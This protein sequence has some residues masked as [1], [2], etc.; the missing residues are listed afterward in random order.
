M[1]NTVER[2]IDEL[3]EMSHQVSQNEL[4]E[5]AQALTEAKRIF[6]AGAG[7]SGCVARAFSNRLMHLGYL[8][9]FVGE[10][11]T[12]P[13]GEGDVLFIIS[14]SGKTTSLIN[15]AKKVVQCKATI[16]TMTIRTEDLENHPI[17]SMASHIIMLPGSTRLNQ[18]G[19]ESIQPVG[20][21]FEQLC[22]LTCDALIVLL[23]Q[24][25]GL[26]NNDLLKNHAN[27]E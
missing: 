9:Y 4:D 8:V 23:K 16:V 25:K 2:I 3:T 19:M 18:T 5:M 15:M 20:T 11:T 1:K 14:G 22:F 13:I 7:R 6:V 12:P 26:E 27:L 24:L 17:G 21:N 10:I